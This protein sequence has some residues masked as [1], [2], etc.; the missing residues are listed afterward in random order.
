MNN[1]TSTVFVSGLTVR[2]SPNDKMVILGLVDALSSS[3]ESE[4][5]YNTY[6]FALPQSIIAKLSQNLN[7]ACEDLGIEIED[8]NNSQDGIE[9]Q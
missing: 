2:T 6:S 5:S 3:N 7:Q 9:A 1:N 4:D 8:T